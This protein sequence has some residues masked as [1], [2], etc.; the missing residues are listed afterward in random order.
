MA[1]AAETRIGQF[2]SEFNEKYMAWKNGVQSG[3]PGQNQAAVED[4]LR[5]WRQYSEELRAQSETI[6]SND[7]IMDALSMLVTQVADEKST[8]IKLQSEAITRTDQADTLNPKTRPS[9]YTNVL[10][11]QRTFRSPTRIGIL[12]A[13]IVFGILA[14]AVLSVLVYRVVV[15][16]TAVRPGFV[17]AGGGRKIGGSV[18]GGGSGSGGGGQHTS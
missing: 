3:M 12:I 15:S 16:G 9:P 14:L 6:M 17:M 1:A 2:M 4:V 11:L 13:S 8:L 7:G 18:G 5:R 10:G